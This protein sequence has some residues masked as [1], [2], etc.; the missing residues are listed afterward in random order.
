MLTIRQSLPSDTPGLIK[1]RTTWVEEQT[2]EPLEEPNFELDYRNWEEN[3]PRTMFIA[4]LDGIIVGMLNLMVLERMPQPGKKT[5][6]W[7][8]PGNAFIVAQH[9]NM[10]VGSR[11]MDAA[12]QFSQDIHA[13]RILLSSTDESHAFYARHGFVSAD[14][15]LVKRF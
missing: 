10:G 7:I 2:N 8:Y 4:K 1:L 6:C 12:T 14:E 3:N 9:R 11:L 13:V 5:T 15:L